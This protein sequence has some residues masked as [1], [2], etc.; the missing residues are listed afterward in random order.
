M[1]VNQK[2][3]MSCSIPS[4]VVST[5]TMRLFDDVV[6]ASSV[7]DANQITNEFWVALPCQT[8]FRLKDTRQLLVYIREVI[9]H[10]LFT[11]Q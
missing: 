9:Q 8:S 2:P 7:G 1:N 6:L 10:T 4:L 3:G 5:H 11:Q